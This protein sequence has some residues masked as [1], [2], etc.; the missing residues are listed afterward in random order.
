MTLEEFD[1]RNRTVNGALL[2]NWPL[3]LIIPI[4]AIVVVY[5][6]AMHPN[7]VSVRYAGVWLGAIVF[8]GALGMSA[9][10][11]WLINTASRRVGLICP[12]C[13][14]PLGGYVK[15]VRQ[16]CRC[17]QCSHVIIESQ[18]PAAQ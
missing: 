10:L 7:Q 9:I 4:A 15:T 1:A 14:A 8:G 3:I 16:T 2:K 18:M 13:N 6:F 11:S 17:P 5:E 12:A